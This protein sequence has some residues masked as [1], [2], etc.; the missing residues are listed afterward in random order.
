MMMPYDR[1]AA[2]EALVRAIPY[3]RLF[4]GTTFVVKV[5]GGSCADAAT[6]DRLIEQIAV[7]RELGIRI[8]L[9]HGG[10]PQTTELC[11]R[12]GIETPFVG[13]R[14]VT[15]PQA[16]EAAVMALNGTVRTALLSA[17]R[18]ASVPA[19]GLSGL[20]AGLVQALQ[21]LP[22]RAEID[23]VQTAVDYGMVGDIQLVQPD[24][25][26]ALLDRSMVPVVSPL[27]GDPDGRVL[28]VNAD[29][30]AAGIAQALGAQKLVFVTSAPGLLA[31][32]DDVTS[33][34]SYTDIKGLE[35]LE[36]QG[37]ITTGMLP[38]V[39]ATKRSLQNGVTRVHMVG[40]R[41]H[42]GLLVEILT[43]E[44]AGTLIVRDMTELSP[45]EMPSPTVRA[46]AANE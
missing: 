23:G 21:R 27:C 13:G 46:K 34:I 42:Y 28:N 8:V 19:V 16:L 31:R 41:V 4:R 20:D 9:V 24:A 6:R 17:F 25:L 32:H 33:L 10:G 2:M 40:H 7:L 5:G 11:G 3:L 30:V 44:G 14:R 15:S 36:Q 37:A 45:S 35:Q 29:T 12:L 1:N 22:Q 39:L 18:R 43:N 26:R 38:K